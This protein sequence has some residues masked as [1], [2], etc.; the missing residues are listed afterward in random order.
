MYKGT[1]MALL[2]VNLNVLSYLDSSKSANPKLKQLD[3]SISLMGMPTANIKNIPISLMPNESINVVSTLRALSYTGGNVFA[4]SKNQS[5][6]RFTGS[7]G[8]RTGRTDGDATTQWLISKNQDLV[9]ATFTGT[10]TAPNFG[11]MQAGDGI[12]LDAPFSSL[13]RGDFIAVKIGANYVQYVNPIAAGETIVGQVDV[14]SSGPVQKGDILDL[15]STQ[16]AFPNNGQF[17]I[18]RITD[19]FIEFSNPNAVPETGITGVTSGLNIYKDAYKWL[20]LII[21]NKVY[22]KLNG[23]NDSTCEVEPPVLQDLENNP[24][25]MLKR[26][27]VFQVDISNPTSYNVIGQLFLAE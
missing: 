13:N 2:N 11:S 10:G 25:M 5:T 3:T 20:F 27:R 6:A 18:S 22:V 15:T 12:T 14:Y 23:N 8:Q 7:F 24:G 17:V 1:K 21:D 9:T 16:F 4:V 26:G 19:S